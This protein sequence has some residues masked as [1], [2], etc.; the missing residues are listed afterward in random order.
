MRVII[1]VHPSFNI[2]I[3]QTRLPGLSGEPFGGP[4]YIYIYL[5]LTSTVEIARKCAKASFSRQ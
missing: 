5:L 4:I 2:K 3:T 1:K